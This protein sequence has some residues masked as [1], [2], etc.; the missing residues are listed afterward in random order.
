MTK[1]KITVKKYDTD[2]WSIEVDGEW[3]GTLDRSKPMRY[4]SSGASLYAVDREK[5]WRYTLSW[6][7]DLGFPNVDLRD[8]IDLKGAK[9]EA[10]SFVEEMILQK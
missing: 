3:V 10:K 8:G 7:S 1:P 2:E 4:S 5:P 6:S 9:A